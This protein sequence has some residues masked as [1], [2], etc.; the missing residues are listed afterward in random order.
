M[1]ND[2]CNERR[3]PRQ[4][5]SQ[6]RVLLSDESVKSYMKVFFDI[7]GTLTVDHHWRVLRPGT[8]GV[9]RELVA[10]HKSVYLW[11]R[12]GNGHCSML[13]TRFPAMKE[14]VSGVATKPY[15]RDMTDGRVP[16]NI[17]C[18]D[19]RLPDVLVETAPDL[20][21]D[22]A[23]THLL[24]AYGGILV[25]TYK[26]PEETSS[27]VMERVLETILKQKQFNPYVNL[28]EQ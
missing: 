12:R 23:G 8:L 22:N 20:C 3:I 21:V 4:T 18:V 2:K 25:P 14:Y 24:L 5:R 16:R 10:S 11:S 1:D 19:L 9:F 13:V 6:S 17:R 15:K 7:D 27:V 28:K 26:D